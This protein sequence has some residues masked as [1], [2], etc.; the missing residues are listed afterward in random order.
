MKLT[1]RLIFVILFIFAI[2]YITKIE[3]ERYESSSIALLKD[4]SKKQNIDLSNLVLGQ[5]S[6]TMQDSKVLELYIRSHEMFDYIDKKFHLRQH[7]SDNELDFAQRL[8]QNAILPSYKA[9]E[10]NLLKKYNDN[11]LVVY[12]DPSGTLKLTFIHTNAKTAQNILQAILKRAEEA[13]NQFSKENA[14]VALHFI[15]KQKEEKRKQFTASIRKLIDYQNKHHTIDPTVDVERKIKILTDLET[16]LIKNKVEYSSKLRTW[17]PNGS[18]MKMLKATIDNIKK[19]IVK[20]KKELSGE[21]NG[22]E[23]NANVF[24]FQLLKSDMEFAKELYRQTLINQENIKI[25]VAQKSK[26]I[27]VVAEPTLADDYSYPNKAWDIFTVMII[28]FF[29]YSVL[30]TSIII[31]QNHRD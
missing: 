2:V 22:K 9:N 3:T 18:E 12:D 19:S 17:N 20:V 15:K 25:E 31:I 14:E 29:I 13:I 5:T 21:K 16:E 4:L 30:M 8:Y 11:L 24:D 28:L 1:I 7:Y 6:S 10:N 26:H 27:V 23:L